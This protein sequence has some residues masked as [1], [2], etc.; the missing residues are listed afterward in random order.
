MP[1]NMHALSYLQNFP[2]SISWRIPEKILQQ[3][4]FI[5]EELIG[6]T[7]A[8]DRMAGG[9]Y[10]LVLKKALPYFLPFF[11]LAGLILYVFQAQKSE[12][13]RTLVEARERLH[14][15]MIDEAISN[16]LRGIAVDLK[17][18]SAH[19]EMEAALQTSD[20][21]SN[22][23][24][25]ALHLAPLTKEFVTFSEIKRFYDQIRLLDLKGMERIRVNL[26][27][28]RA[29]VAPPEALQ[30]KSHRSYFKAAMRLTVSIAVFQ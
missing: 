13:E 27:N 30:N 14:L 1:N 8:S 17:M 29:V 20:V 21:T 24:D 12:E 3:C 18:L 19:H 28:G 16:L 23:I 7:S 15:E 2:I 25:K 22:S 26:V 10:M 9:N 11:I 6:M 4:T 5:Q